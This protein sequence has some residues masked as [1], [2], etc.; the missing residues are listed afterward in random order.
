[1]QSA[2]SVHVRLL[3]AVAAPA[4]H[5]EEPH[6]AAVGPAGLEVPG[7]GQYYTPRLLKAALA[8]AVGMAWLSSLDGE[9]EI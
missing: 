8:N 5:P 3:P 4:H 7:Q 2:D 1:M 6:R 9:S